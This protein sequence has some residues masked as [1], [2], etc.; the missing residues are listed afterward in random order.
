MS[1]YTFYFTSRGY[2]LTGVAMNFECADDA[3]A[4]KKAKE[5]ISTASNKSDGIEI[6]EEIE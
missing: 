1:G 3:A 6:W 4:F 2:H 5:I